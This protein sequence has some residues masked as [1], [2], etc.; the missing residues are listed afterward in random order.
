LDIEATKTITTAGLEHL[1]ELPALEKLKLYQI[2]T[3]NAGLGNEAL[4]IVAPIRTL[5]DLSIEE[6]NVTDDGAR[7]LEGMTQLTAL[8]LSGNQLTDAGMKSLAGL[9][10][11]ESLDVS[12]HMQIT[13]EGIKQLSR[14]TELRQ[15]T[16]SSLAI[17]GKGVPFPH[18]QSLFLSGEL[19]TDAALDSI[20]QCR[21]LRRLGLSFTLVTRESPI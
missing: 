8:N 14:L 5:R 16:P 7:A 10:N 13:D 3:G 11:L 21:D 15:F 6:C 18:L 9:T 19:V 2:N 20:I 4:R 12:S 1:T 17:S